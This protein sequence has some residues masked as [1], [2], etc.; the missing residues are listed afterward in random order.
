MMVKPTQVQ[1]WMTANAELHRD[2]LT[3]EIN[4]TSLAED[5][6]R[7]FNM[8]TGDSP[9]ERLFDWAYAVALADEAARTR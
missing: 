9:T 1:Q 8:Y 5:A 6:A 2:P 3:A 4:M 7:E